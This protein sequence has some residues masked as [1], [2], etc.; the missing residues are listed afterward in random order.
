MLRSAFHRV[1]PGMVAIATAASAALLAPAAHAA[2]T[3]NLLVLPDQGESAIYSFI[4][5][6][7]KSVDV[8]MYELRDTTVTTDVR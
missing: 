1:G 7:T 8:T 5:S 6:A 4:N 3:Y 2:G